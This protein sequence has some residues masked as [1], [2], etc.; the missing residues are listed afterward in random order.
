VP[1]ARKKAT[2]IEA[3]IGKRLRAIR[4]MRG[5]SQSTVAAALGVN[6]SR[7]TEYEQGGLRLHAAAILA[8]ARTLKVS[9]DDLLGLRK[10]ELARPPSPRLLQRLQR[11]EKLPADERRAVLKI[12]DSL[13]ERH[14]GN[15][16]S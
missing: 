9:T 15:G 12:L 4:E 14:R 5:K 7:I 10:S 1:R 6:Q 16:H 2:P 13:L 8:L 3:T 11:I